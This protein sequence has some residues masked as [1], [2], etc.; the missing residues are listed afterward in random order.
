[1]LVDLLTQLRGCEWVDLT[2]AFAPGIP[3]Y[4]GFPDEVRRVLF[5][6]DV[7]VGEHGSG[8]LAHEYRHI[9]QW[10]APKTRWGCAR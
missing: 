5:H 9:G 7:G 4:V 8:F 3:H 6:F 1:M 2:H 10:V